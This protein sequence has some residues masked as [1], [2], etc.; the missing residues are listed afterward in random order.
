MKILHIIIRSSYDG[1][2]VLPIGIIE[3]LPEYKHQI[4]SFF[5][6]S[7]F[8]EIIQKDIPYT[9]FIT[10]ESL[11]KKH[12]LGK[13]V[14]VVQF[15]NHHN[16]DIIHFHTGGLGV[17]L[18]TY[19]FRGKAKVIFHI[20]SGNISGVPNKRK[21]FLWQKIVLRYLNNR[22]IQIAVAEHVTKNYEAQIGS[23]QNISLVKN[24]ENYDFKEKEKLNYSVG[25]LGRV[26]EA[27]NFNILFNIV[28]ELRKQSTKISVRVKGDIYPSRT[29]SI[30]K[31]MS[32]FNYEFPSFSIEQFFSQI[33]L[34]LFPSLLEECRPLVILEALA[35]D[36][37]IIAAKTKAV[38]EILGEYPLLVNTI[39]VESI[40]E[41]IMCFYSGQID[42]HYLTNL[43]RELYSKHPAKDS[44]EKI[45]NIYETP[46]L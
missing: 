39:E 23:K 12:R 44:I 27:K 6:G 20:H 31:I 29:I 36:T 37:P 18:L 21:L 24:F 14:F 45:R 38:V 4:L 35:F 15:L 41:K 2:V 40:M 19:L 33:D 16:F 3:S 10:D 8:Q 7:A 11:S 32:T 34:L 43:H 28:N 42:R 46:Y 30:D 1:A 9:D 5:R 17:L 22:T 26:I 13:F 25:F